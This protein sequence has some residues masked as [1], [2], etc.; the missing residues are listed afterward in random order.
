MM[1]EEKIKKQ[2]G[3]NNSINFK[4]FKIELKKYL[5]IDIPDLDM[6]NKKE[7][8]IH[9]IIFRIYE[10]FNLMKKENQNFKREL[11][12]L[13]NE[14]K[15][16]LDQ[17]SNLSE[18]KKKKKTKEEKKLNI[19][20][21][22]NKFLKSD[23]NKKEA[24]INQI[25]KN[26]KKNLKE[27]KNNFFISDLNQGLT[28][29]LKKDKKNIVFHNSELDYNNFVTKKY[30]EIIFDIFNKNL[31]QFF[32][33]RKNFLLG[34][35]DN[36][37]NLK[38]IKEIKKIDEIFER[39]DFQ[40]NSLFENL[41]DLVKFIDS[42]EFEMIKDFK[43]FENKKI[44]H[45][46]KKFEMKEKINKINDIVNLN[47]LINDY[48]NILE[49]YKNMNII[50]EDILKI[51][52][53]YPSLQTNFKLKTVQRLKNNINGLNKFINNLKNPDIY[54]DISENDLYEDTLKKTF[55]E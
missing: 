9:D 41:N 5:N 23:L 47:L 11:K 28:N 40:I 8:K 52:I 4:Y 1:K 7:K 55:L 6:K 22:E 16:I 45:S 31:K 13:K 3:K 53:S 27:K 35:I 43:Y 39:K 25:K 21:K 24:E 10:N 2:E 48:Q 32:N 33:K 34:K 19:L 44:F 49:K 38:I 54:H 30:N 46:I 42:F 50:Y 12:T 29:N 37:E 26:L 17:L 51:K 14:N 18:K 36:L 20:E 15:N